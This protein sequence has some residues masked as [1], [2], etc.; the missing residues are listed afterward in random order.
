MLART[1]Q[2]LSC[3][4]VLCQ[5][6]ARRESFWW[7]SF[8]SRGPLS[9][10]PNNANHH[11]QP[12]T[13]PNFLRISESTGVPLRTQTTAQAPKH[14]CRPSRC[15]FAVVLDQEFAITR[16]KPAQGIRS[17]RL[18]PNYE[19]L[20]PPGMM[21]MPIEPQTALPFSCDSWLLHLH[22]GS[23]SCNMWIR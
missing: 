1:K 23:S 4:A 14:P 8:C 3:A 16:V 2:Y 17:H 7:R 22:G 11:D 18:F 9:L 19:S 13:R 15:L 10:T 12:M 5:R 20:L 6:L 21:S